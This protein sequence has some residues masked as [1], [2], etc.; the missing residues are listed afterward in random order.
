MNSEWVKYMPAGHVVLKNVLFAPLPLENRVVGLIG[1][2]NKDGDFTEH[3]LRIAE[4]LGKIAAIAL[5]NSRSKDL[6]EQREKELE[7]AIEEK[8]YLM[9][10]LNHR[11]K[12]NLAMVS[13]LVNLK[14]DEEDTSKDFSD[15]KQQIDAI[16]TVHEQLISDN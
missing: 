4:N 11:V 9:K 14:V 7:K 13:S 16:R 12:N 6:L 2:A 8:K 3:N 1:L 10:E 5:K 15:I